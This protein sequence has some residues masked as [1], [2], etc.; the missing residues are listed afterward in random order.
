MHWVAAKGKQPQ[1]V[2]LPLHGSGNKNGEGDNG[3]RI[4]S[5]HMPKDNITTPPNWRLTLLDEALH[6][7]HNFDP[8]GTE[9]A[10]GGAEGLK[11]I[12]AAH[13][14]KNEHWIGEPGKTLESGGIG[15]VR[16]GPYPNHHGSEDH[17]TFVAIEPL[18]GNTV[19]VYGPDKKRT[20]LDETLAQG[21]ALAC[22]SFLPGDR[23]QIVAGWRDKN[24][25]GK[26]G[27]RMYLSVEGQW[28][29]HTIDD[30]TMACEDLKA[31]DL[32]GDGKLDII[33]SGRTTK[34]VVIYWNE[35]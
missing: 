15:E 16:W 28:I 22:G 26:V 17:R 20:V 35:S 9:L 4:F 25:E 11:I 5:Y 7:S 12:N 10:I 27:I 21:H 29:T 1:L 14:A 2:V 33:A 34:N 31:A 8:F 24:A 18:H 19:V 6:K 3:A 32:N 13:P 30:D 23:Q